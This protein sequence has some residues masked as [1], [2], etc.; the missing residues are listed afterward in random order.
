MAWL[1]KTQAAAS[2]QPVVPVS[3]TGSAA[4]EAPSQGQRLID[5]ALKELRAGQYQ[6]A[7]KLANEAFDPKYAV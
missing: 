3:A 6:T 4:P 7:R 2:G 5:D 1:E